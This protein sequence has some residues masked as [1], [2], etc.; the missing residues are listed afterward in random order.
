VGMTSPISSPQNLVA[1]HTIQSTSWNYTNPDTGKVELMTGNVGWG[2][3]LA[4]SIP[5]AA[6]CTV[7]CWAFLW[8]V[9]RP[10]IREVDPIPPRQLEPFGITHVVVLLV[11]LTTVILWALSK[12]IAG[13]FGDPGIIGLIPVVMFFYSTCITEI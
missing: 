6:L 4:V 8:L 5:F 9:F 7:V 12:N 11:C 10:K 13:V 1:V 3:W 2:S